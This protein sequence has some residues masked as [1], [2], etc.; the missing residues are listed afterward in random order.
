MVWLVIIQMVNDSTAPTDRIFS[1][2]AHFHGHD[3]DSVGGEYSGIVVKEKPASDFGANHHLEMQRS[4]L[5]ETTARMLLDCTILVDLRPKT[6][7]R[8]F[9]DL[10]CCSKGPLQEFRESKIEDGGRSQSARSDRT[11]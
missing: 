7:V 3:S 2:P 4:W 10:V 5:T 1:H 9:D 8:V 6:N 11:V